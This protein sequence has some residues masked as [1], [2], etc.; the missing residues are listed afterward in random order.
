MSRQRFSAEQ[1]RELVLEYLDV[2]YGQR[3]SWA[4]AR[5]VSRRSLG[6]WREQVVTGLLE[7]D[8]VVRGGVAVPVEENREIVRLRKLLAQREAEL[9]AVRA[10]DESKDRVIDALGKAI[11]LLRDGPARG[12]E[13]GPGRP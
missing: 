9:D 11:E 13:D 3:V 6:R 2:P 7:V 1:K 8:M 5:G 4:R 10:R 12:R